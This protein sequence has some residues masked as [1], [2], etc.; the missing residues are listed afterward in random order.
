M[1]LQCHRDDNPKPENQGVKALELNNNPF[2]NLEPPEFISWIENLAGQAR[3]NSLINEA[4]I[5]CSSSY[6]A[7]SSAY[8][9]QSLLCRPIAGH[10]NLCPSSVSTKP[11]ELEILLSTV[12]HEMLHALGFSVSLFAFYRDKVIHTKESSEWVFHSNQLKIAS[13]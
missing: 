6:P 11:Q 1:S 13:S 4:L 7:Y 12:K 5:N 9:N 10:A 2:H 3:C 8:F